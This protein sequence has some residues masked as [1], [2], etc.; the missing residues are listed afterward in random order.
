M[1]KL[2]SRMNRTD[3]G[4]LLF[5]VVFVVLQVY[6]DMR[7]PEFL[8]E[9]LKVANN[10]S[11]SLEQGV[12]QIRQV[13]VHMAL[14][15]LVSFILSAISS[16]IIAKAVMNFVTKI[17]SDIFEKVQSLSVPDVDKFTVHGLITRS[18][19]DVMNIQT[20]ILI[21]FQALVKAPIISV[22]ALVKIGAYGV[23]IND[24]KIT[25]LD[26]P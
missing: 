17:R 13:A 22:W 1:I 21:G 26:T 5:S 25:F 2:F 15:V 3:K 6:F 9:A 12:V 8:S 11:A 4:L 23:K 18:T 14:C 7:I 16:V 24:Q 20:F 19:S 10:S